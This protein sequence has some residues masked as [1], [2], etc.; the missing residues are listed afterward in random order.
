MIF[1][2]FKIGL[3]IFFSEAICMYKKSHCDL[4]DITRQASDA[5]DLDTNVTQNWID[6]MIGWWK[7]LRRSRT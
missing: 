7:K 6:V 1:E 4:D 5:A 2:I 3:Y